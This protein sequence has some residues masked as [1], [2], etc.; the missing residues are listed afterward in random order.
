[1]T[2]GVPRTYTREDSGVGSERTADRPQ[3]AYSS[4]ADYPRAAEP[5]RLGRFAAAVSLARQ[6]HAAA[7]VFGS[8]S[9]RLAFGTLT[10]LAGTAIFAAAPAAAQ[11]RPLPASSATPWQLPDPKSANVEIVGHVLEPKQLEPT[12]ERLARL[13]LPD[14]FEIGMFA[15]DLINPR[16]MAVADDGTIYVTRRAVGD[17]V[18]LRDEDGD[19]KA[20]TKQTVASRPMM[21]GIAIDGDTVYL[22]TVTEI[23]RAEI[24]EDGTLGPLERIVD[25]LPAGGQH[26]NR[27]VVVGP[28]GKLYVSVGST[29][30]ACAETDPENATILRVEPDGSSRKIFASGLRNSMDHGIDWLGDRE[31]GEELNHIVAGH[32]Y[33]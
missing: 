1:M 4:F 20:D 3:S 13:D 30:N 14:G 9:M 12:D 31:Q 17:V 6:D 24:L 27:M 16:M 29:C 10:V 18:M 23:Y 7:L 15:R 22:T 8:L 32:K 28:D 33:G 25:D 11:N 19:G 5:F 2:A 26:P 21:H